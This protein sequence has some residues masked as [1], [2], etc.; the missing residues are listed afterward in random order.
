MAFYDPLFEIWY[1]IEEGGV[2]M[3]IEIKENGS[4]NVQNKKISPRERTVLKR[5]G[6]LKKAKTKHKRN[7]RTINE[8]YEQRYKIKHH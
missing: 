1:N 2:S 3:A 6:F 7:A 4:I 8:L 5:Y